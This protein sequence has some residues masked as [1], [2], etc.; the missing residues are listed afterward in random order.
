MRNS[1]NVKL[2]VRCYWIFIFASA[3]FGT[4]RKDNRPIKLRKRLDVIS[5][6]VTAHAPKIGSAHLATPPSV[7]P[8]G[9]P[10]KKRLRNERRNSILMTCHYPDVG[11]ASDR[12]FA[13]RGHVTSFLRKWKLHDFAFEKRLVGHILNKTIVIWFF[14]PAPFS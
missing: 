11:S 3:I 1:W 8:P 4:T 12:P 2:F 9:F 13:L 10:A 5:L 6:H 14:K 7:F